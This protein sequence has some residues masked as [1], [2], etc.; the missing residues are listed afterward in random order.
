MTLP[1]ACL[2]LALAV[3]AAGGCAT[4]RTGRLDELNAAFAARY[5]EAPAHV[6]LAR[7]HHDQGHRRVAF[8]ILESARRRFEPAEFDEAFA[9][10]FRGA[11]PVDSSGAAEAAL[12]Q[13]L[14]AHERD[15]PALKGLA[16]IYIARDEWARATRYLERVVELKPDDFPAVAALTDAYR[17]QGETAEAARVARTFVDAH[18]DSRE[19]WE[20]RVDEAMQRDRTG[21]AQLLRTALE[22]Y[23]KDPILVAH[24][25]ALLQ[26]DGKLAEAGV[27][28][29][30]AAALAADRPE[31]QSWAARFFLTAVPDPARAV[32]YALN[33]YFLDPRFFDGEHAE[34]RVRRLELEVAGEEL[35]GLLAAHRAAETLLGH[36]DPVVVGLAITAMSENW[37]AAYAPPL[38]A[39]LGHDDP[40]VRASAMKAL[41]T[42]ADRSFDQDLKELLADRDPRKRGLAAH[43]AVHL[44]ER[45]SFAA[46]KT[47][48]S[49]P[50]EL[51]RYEAFSALVL[52]GGAEGRELALAYREQESNP[53]LKRLLTR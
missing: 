30:R 50:V 49:D 7:Y 11:R 16:E 25:A 48:L 36:R 26:A 24:R 44:W 15:V 27:E 5:L 2:A 53:R 39:T 33:V 52:E 35:K 47:L 4:V 38:F 17:R 19:A 46:I 40:I 10:G 37:R 9:A 3:L 23:P 29:E 1:T 14:A 6:A 12:L 45:D 34:A 20:Y 8:S 51:V 41:K 43:I 13:R 31:V 32:Q 21:A 28:I 22:S 42:H 18:P